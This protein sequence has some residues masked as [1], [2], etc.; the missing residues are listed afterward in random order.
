LFAVAAGPAEGLVEVFFAAAFPGAFFSAGAVRFA[1]EG[2]A[3]TLV[4][5]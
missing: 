2:G 5:A 4:P 3:L 1:G